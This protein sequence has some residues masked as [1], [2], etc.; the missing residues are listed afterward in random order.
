MYLPLCQHA[1]VPPQQEAVFNETVKPLVAGLFEAPSKN[2]MGIAYGATNAG[3][4]H[5]IMGTPGNDGVLPRALEAMFLRVQQNNVSAAACAAFRVN[6]RVVEVYKNYL[7]DLLSESEGR[8]A[9][10]TVN[11]TQR[12][13][14]VID[15]LSSHHPADLGE[16]LKLVE[17]ATDKATR[18][19]T[20]LNAASSRGHTVWMIEL[21]RSEGEG[22][23]EPVAASKGRGGA[24]V[25][26]S[27]CKVA[28]PRLWLFDLAGSERIDRSKSDV[29]EAN[30]INIDLSALFNCLKQS[31][32]NKKRVSYRART[33][34]RMMKGMLVKEADVAGA[35]AHNPG[36]FG[37][38][39]GASASSAAATPRL[40]SC[41]MIVNVHPALS[42]Y[43]ETQ[44]VL[45]NA[46]ISMKARAVEERPRCTGGGGESAVYGMNGHLVFKRQKSSHSVQHPGADG[47]AFCAASAASGQ[48]EARGSATTGRPRGGSSLGIVTGSRDEQLRKY[49][50]LKRRFD[51]AESENA[52]LK[53]RLGEL[54]EELEDVDEE[55]Q[56]FRQM[57]NDGVA[58]LEVRRFFMSASASSWSSWSWSSL[59]GHSRRCCL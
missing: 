37:W 36:R 26:A 9:A 42:E 23:G 34:T 43:G 5:T 29:F 50:E 24:A 38:P 28:N 53:E 33:L 25:G 14:D 47:P 49:D 56:E 58:K 59:P 1:V 2:G 12:D 16:A 11:E 41:V 7:Y 8:G 21:Q 6:L 45:T 3:K 35:G 39:G 44:K 20:A 18:A 17:R 48:G 52:E 19:E 46:L 57:F 4:T 55:R 51:E 22:S 10:L 30:N 32:T 40:T 13:G 27:S 15:G 54:E 31:E